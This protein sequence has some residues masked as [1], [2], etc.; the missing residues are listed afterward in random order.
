MANILPKLNMNIMPDPETSHPKW[1]DWQ[2]AVDQSLLR[3]ALMKCT[4]IA[5]WG[6]MPFGSGANQCTMS[7]AGK[8]LMQQAPEAYLDSVSEQVMFDRNGLRLIDRDEWVQVCGKKI[9]KALHCL[10]NY[11]MKLSN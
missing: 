6:D 4:L 7:D 11:Q 3:A 1:N 8:L 10:N 9:P 5:N 2:L